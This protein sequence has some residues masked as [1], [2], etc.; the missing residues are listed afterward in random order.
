MISKTHISYTQNKSIASLSIYFAYMIYLELGKSLNA[1][2]SFV[3]NVY[4][5]FNK[6]VHWN[7]VPVEISKC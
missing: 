6:W 1:L 7:K 3:L 4:P 5:R 2:N